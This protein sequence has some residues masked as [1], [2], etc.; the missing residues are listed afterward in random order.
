MYPRPSVNN[1]LKPFWVLTFYLLPVLMLVSYGS[2]S[3]P[4]N[5][6]WSFFLVGCFLAFLGAF[7]YY[8]F[9]TKQHPD[10]KPE[11]EITTPHSFDEVQFESERKMYQEQLVSM[12]Q[13]FESFRQAAEKQLLLKD[14]QLR[15][16][17]QAAKE[18]KKVIEKHMQHISILENKERDLHRE[19]KSLLKLS[20]EGHHHSKSTQLEI[21]DESPTYESQTNALDSDNPLKRYL[22]AASQ[23][24]GAFFESSFGDVNKASFALDLR[25][26]FDQ[27]QDPHGNVLFVYSQKEN[28][29]IFVNNNV[30]NTLGWSPELFLQNF[31][32]IIHD[33]SN[34]W[35]QA[36]ELLPTY[37]EANIK[38]SLKSKNGTHNNLSCQFAVIQ[39]GLFRSH[40]L[41]IFLKE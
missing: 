27:L 29:I 13:E 6:K 30:K 41:G 35:Q 23:M 24:T 11:T 32:E 16:V 22:E 31:D 7:L 25:R 1:N 38:L 10:S 40:A 21:F 18:K 9:F 28:R 5:V 17:Q 37:H 3:M 12:R 4:L 20:S 33:S 19:F 14:Q 2:L 39:S 36:L 8:L 15:E 26:L 34:A